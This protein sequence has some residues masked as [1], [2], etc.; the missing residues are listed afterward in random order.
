MALPPLFWTLKHYCI[1]PFK[2]R[3][4]PSTVYGRKG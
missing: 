3:S 1:S 4:R 2:L